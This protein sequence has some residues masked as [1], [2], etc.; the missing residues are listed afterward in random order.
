[1]ALCA[2]GRT[3]MRRGE[4]EAASALDEALALALETE[5]LQRI[6]PVRLASGIAPTRTLLLD[7]SVEL[8]CMVHR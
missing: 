4:S 8:G 7:Y 1:M 2:L 3:Q 6:A 5:T